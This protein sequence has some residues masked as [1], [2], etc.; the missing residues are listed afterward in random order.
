MRF[1]SELPKFQGMPTRTITLSYGSGESFETTV[2]GS[3]VMG[4]KG[5]YFKTFSGCYGDSGFVLLA[6]G[7]DI[8]VSHDQSIVEAMESF[9][10]RMS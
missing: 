10:Y 2:K 7:D 5:A 9:G 3:P 4:G 8:P 6:T 1:I